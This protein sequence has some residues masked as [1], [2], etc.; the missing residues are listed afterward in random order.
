ML[1]KRFK[2]LA[3][4]TAITFVDELQLQLKV[5]SSVNKPSCAHSTI[6]SIN[7]VKKFKGIEIKL[8]LD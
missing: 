8:H 2:K 1:Q 3:S 7:K 5:G 6:I 4:L